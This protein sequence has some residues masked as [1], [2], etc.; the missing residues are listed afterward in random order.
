M[1]VIIMGIMLGI[2]G[3]SWKMIM[4]REREEELLFRGNQYR[5]ALE[6]WH[7]PAVTPGQHVTTPLNDL[8][9]LLKDPRTAE[10]TRYLRRLYSDPITGKDFEAVRDPVRGIVGVRSSSEEEPIKKGGFPTELKQFEELKQYK[11]WVFG[12]NL[13]TP[14]SQSNQPGQ[15]PQA[16]AEA[17][18]GSR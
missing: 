4:Q 2:A 7:K 1:I 14:S 18:V 9:D 10:K 11:Q 5:L 13:T 17:S 6:K 12:V 15:T 16:G 8:K 3:Q